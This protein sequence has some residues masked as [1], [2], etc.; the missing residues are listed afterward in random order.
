MS[1]TYR[2]RLH[3][4]GPAL[5]PSHK[6]LAEVLRLRDTTPEYI[7]HS[8]YQ[9][10]PVAPGGALFEREWWAEG[11]NRFDA[12][13][14]SLVNQ[15]I[16]RYL[17]FDT[18]MKDRTTSDFTAYTVGELMPDYRLF[19]REVW[20]DKFT[21]PHLLDAIE[22]AAHRHNAD[23]KL[24]QVL[25]EDKNSGTS[26][27]QTLTSATSDPW[28]ASILYPFMPTGSKPLR[29]MQ[30]TPWCMNGSIWLPHPGYE[31][32]W[33]PAFEEQLFNFRP[34]ESE[35]EH[36][37]MVD[38]FVQLCLYLEHFLSEGFHARNAGALAMAAS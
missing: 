31:V 18:A 30:V 25:I 29:A 4:D 20:Q 15:S 32:P 13:D 10:V 16:A 36:D 3:S 19:T 17:S 24:K 23:G 26:A 7:W 5:W 37:D 38:S 33:L 22:G 28:L 9:C 27:Y 6:S 21:F 1:P 12:S 14:R 2:Y 8:T 11:R 34:V 35:N